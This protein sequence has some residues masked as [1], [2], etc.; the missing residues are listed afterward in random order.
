M[1]AV[2]FDY[3]GVL[4]RPFSDEIVHSFA[5]LACVPASSFRE[6]YA[7]SRGP[8]DR[9]VI[10]AED[11]WRSFGQLA[12]QRY[13]EEQVRALVAMDL[14]LFRDVDDQMLEWVARLR[15]AGVKTAILSN[16]PHDLRGELR[17]RDWLRH[18]DVQFFSCDHGLVKPEPEIYQRLL[19]ALAVP[20]Q[21]VL[22]IDDLP[23][24]I[25]AARR[26]GITGLLYRTFDEVA[27]CLAS[28]VAARETG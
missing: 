15:A 20:A 27:G 21:Q 25:E 23:V 12:G 19:Q 10:S 26:E 14:S 16:M 5:A 24:N 8:Y 7:T 17:S 2:V 22:F 4:S 6:M 13:D 9:G 18:F 1:D 3:G 28:V 11:C